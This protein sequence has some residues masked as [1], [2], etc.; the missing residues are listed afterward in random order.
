MK[1]MKLKTWFAVTTMLVLLAACTTVEKEIS[2]EGAANISDFTLFDKQTRTV[3]S[4]DETVQ[5]TVP[6]DWITREVSMN[7][8]NRL[9]I[10]NDQASI[11]L[12]IVQELHSEANDDMNLEK[13]ENEFDANIG[14]TTVVDERTLEIDGV[15]ARERS[16]KYVEN[17]SKHLWMQTFLEKDGAFYLI[18]ISIPESTYSLNKEELQKM[19]ETFKV[20]KPA[21]KEV[22]DSSNSQTMTNDDQSLQ[23]TVPM[24]WREARTN[25]NQVG[26]F[27]LKNDRKAEL[28]LMREFASGKTEDTTLQEIVDGRFENYKQF[29]QGEMIGWRQLL[30]DGQPAYQV[31]GRCE[32]NGEDHGLLIT[33]LLKDNAYYVMV[34]SSPVEDFLIYKREYKRILESFQVLKHVG[35]QSDSVAMDKEQSEVFDNKLAS[36]KI[37]LTAQWKKINLDQDAQLQAIHPGDNTLF[38]AYGEQASEDDTLT[39]DDIYEY[40]ISDSLLESPKWSKPE[41]IKIQDYDAIYFK[42]TGISNGTKATIIVAITRSSRQYTQLMFVGKQDVMEANEDWY[43]K[44]I[45]TYSERLY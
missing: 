40:Y 30:I 10:H 11:T 39:L 22:F 13:W 31:E 35:E 5:I 20:L 34:I 26:E 41:P 44:A 3:M 37:E 29:H 36:M 32:Y 9:V 12:S 7:G 43:K 15:P 19:T 23:I 33:A 8:N 1:F 16:I 17:Y 6:E 38:F 24:N 25:I 14:Q 45:S 2:G 18:S 28:L 4:E 42:G 21:E 27:I